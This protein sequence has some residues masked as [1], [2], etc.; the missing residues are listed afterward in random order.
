MK[1]VISFQKLDLWE[2]RQIQKQT[3]VIEQ[4][5]E[6]IAPESGFYRAVESR[7]TEEQ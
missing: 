4:E 1:Q 3:S 2:G 7:H 5:A 6:I